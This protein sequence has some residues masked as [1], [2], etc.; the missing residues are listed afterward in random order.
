M[1]PEGSKA[2]TRRVRLTKQR[3]DNFAPDT[4]Q[5]Q[6]FLWDEEVPSLAVRATRGG[7]KAFVFQSK[8]RG[9]VVRI[10]IGSIADWHIDGQDARRS[11]RKEARRLRTLVDRGIDPRAEAKEQAEAA[12]AAKVRANLEE[13]TLRDIWPDYVEARKATWGARHLLDHER[14]ADPGGRKALRGDRVTDPGALAALMSV[15][16][17]KIDAD[18]V[19]AWLTLETKT[20]P[21]QARLAFGALRACL[22]W[23]AESPT[24]R[25]L[26]H[27]DAC[28]RRVS[29]ETLPKKGAKSDALQREQLPAWFAA[30]RSL[31]DPVVSAYLQ[32]LLLT[33]ARREELATLQWANIEFKWHTLR[34]RDK[35]EGERVI[36]LTVHMSALLQKLKK[37]NETPRQNEKG[38]IDPTWKP[39]PWVF[40]SDRSADGRLVE[41]RIAHNRALATAELPHLSL[42]GLRRSFASLAEWVEVPSGVVAQIMGHKPSATAERHYIVRP[43][44]LLRK[45]HQTLEDWILKEGR[46]HVPRRKKGADR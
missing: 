11:A 41:P 24:Y 44:D 13:T 35:V 17:G 2:S 40:S 7:S 22:N 10:T 20:R 14:L 9:E 6:A 42:H 28:T 36:P 45:W 12:H 15:P 3:I 19:R 33:G 4:G 8:L 1:S 18:A 16:L 34:I 46:V 43:V 5:V 27:P 38:E 31:S 25:T 37:I 26:V 29:T 30:V 23:L 21:T 32:G 39:S